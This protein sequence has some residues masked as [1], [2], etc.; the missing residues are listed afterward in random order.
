MQ[1]AGV[2]VG[3]GGSAAGQ[4]SAWGWQGRR[5]RQVGRARRAGLVGLAGCGQLANMCPGGLMR[6]SSVR[7]A[8]C[9]FAMDCG[10]EHGEQHPEHA[11]TLAIQE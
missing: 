9:G 4:R 10:E 1:R 5:G 2:S 8:W 7:R 6:L 11:L 3:G